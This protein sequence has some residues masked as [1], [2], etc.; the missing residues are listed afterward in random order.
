[1]K[2]TGGELLVSLK[3]ITLG[4]KDFINPGI[5]P[6]H[7]ALLTVSDQGTGM[8]EDLIKK[9][10]DPFFTTKEIG[11]GTGMGLSVVHGIIKSMNGTIQVDSKPDIGTAF[12]VYLPVER[13]FCAKTNVNDNS[14]FEKGTENILI[15]DDEEGILLME[16]R[17]LSLM[18]YNSSSFVCSTE[19]LEVF[20]SDPHRFDLVITDLSMPNLTGDRL[21]AEMIKIRPD[22][23][24]L[25]CTGFSDDTCED[26]LESIGIKRLLMKPIVMK[27]LSEKIREVLDDL[28]VRVL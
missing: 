18:G 2:E 5:K 7:Y 3:E 27:D 26:T 15:V 20:R 21:S 28:N 10:F 17:M 9:I 23:P 4:S 13:N 8:D 24:I 14:T 16:E 22:I 6:G 11:K 12:K 1:M 19:A 25:L